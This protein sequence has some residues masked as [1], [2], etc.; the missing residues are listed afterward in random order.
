MRDSHR[1]GCISPAHP[2]PPGDQE[3]RKTGAPADVCQGDVAFPWHFSPTPRTRPRRRPS[4]GGWVHPRLQR[5]QRLPYGKIQGCRRL[6]C[7]FW[8][9]FV[10]VVYNSAAFDAFSDGF[11]IS[12]A[13]ALFGVTLACSC[14]VGSGRAGKPDQVSCGAVATAVPNMPRGCSG[15]GRSGEQT[16][17]A[18]TAR[19]GGPPGW[20]GTGGKEM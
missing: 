19:P 6:D 5:L 16:V 14:P 10:V 7:H 18:Q 8:C 11:A 3:G 12:S 15:Q 4:G 9:N 13:P 20:A 2:R 17:Q 1:T